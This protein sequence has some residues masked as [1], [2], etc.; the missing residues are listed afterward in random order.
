MDDKQF[1]LPRGHERGSAKCSV[2]TKDWHKKVGVLALILVTL[3]FLVWKSLSL[4]DTVNF[5]ELRKTLVYEK[6]IDKSWGWSEVCLFKGF[7]ADVVLTL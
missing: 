4:V 5:E 2:R 6:G 1:L 3:S 7:L